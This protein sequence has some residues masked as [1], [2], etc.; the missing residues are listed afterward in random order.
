MRRTARGDGRFEVGKREGE[1]NSSFLQLVPGN[2][3][4]KSS[5]YSSQSSPRDALRNIYRD[6]RVED[7]GEPMILSREQHHRIRPA[8]LSS[9]SKLTR[10]CLDGYRDAG[11]LL[12]T[13]EATTAN[14]YRVSMS[15][16]I[17]YAKVLWQGN[18]MQLV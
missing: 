9:Q 6:H 16:T 11:L 1:E 14:C 8:N 13:N 18:R 10:P 2:R 3:I 5:P 4:G 15:E 12:R 7:I 17:S